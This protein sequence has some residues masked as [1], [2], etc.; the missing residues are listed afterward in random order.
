MQK[1]LEILPWITTTLGIQGSK[2]PRVQIIDLEGRFDHDHY[3]N[4]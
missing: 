1:G 4:A 2:E 3:T